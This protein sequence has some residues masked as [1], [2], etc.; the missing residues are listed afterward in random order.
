MKSK[1]RTLHGQPVIVDVDLA[2]IIGVATKQLKALVVRRRPKI[3]LEFVFSVPM[4]E[5]GDL[6]PPIAGVL[7]NSRDAHLVLT[8]H[9][10]ILIAAVL[11]DPRAVKLA[12]QVVRTF[13]SLREVHSSDAELT[14]RVGSLEKAIATLDRETQR[15]FKMVNEALGAL[16]ES[17]ARGIR[18]HRNLH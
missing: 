3:P 11:R 17:S 10:V 7:L 2:A 8:V 13:A 1:I 14:R 16:E 18:P 6:D 4:H 15:H 5:L 9:G 12:I